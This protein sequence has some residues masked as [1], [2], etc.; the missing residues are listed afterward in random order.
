[1]T[2]KFISYILRN[3]AIS[4]AFHCNAYQ[5]IGHIFVC[6]LEN[7]TLLCLFMGSLLV[8]FSKAY[9]IVALKGNVEKKKSLL[10]INILILKLKDIC[11]LTLSLP[12]T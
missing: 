11:I 6:I 8:R 10:I 12:K 1:M 7:E 9:M 5:V 2:L 3:L 4:S